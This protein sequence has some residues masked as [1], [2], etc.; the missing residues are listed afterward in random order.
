MTIR[1]P[2]S[3]LAGADVPLDEAAAGNL[4]GQRSHCVHAGMRPN[5]HGT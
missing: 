2:H 3:E 5:P 4:F 1:T